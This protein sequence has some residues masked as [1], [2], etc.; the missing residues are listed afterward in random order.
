[1]MF[2]FGCTVALMVIMPLRKAMEVSYHDK[3]TFKR[4]LGSKISER[5]DVNTNS[6]IRGRTLDEYVFPL[7]V[8]KNCY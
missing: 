1:M 7:L 5:K 3:K 4:S 8:L 6:K 2:A